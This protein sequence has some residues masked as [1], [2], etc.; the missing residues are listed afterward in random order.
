[1]ITFNNLCLKYVTV[2]FY[3]I[4]RS[5]TTVFNVLFTYYILKEKTSFKA[6]SCCAC[7]IGGFFLGVDQEKVGGSLSPLGVVFGVCASACVALNAIYTK[8]TLPVVSQD[9]WQLQF[10]NNLNAVILF[11]PLMIVCGEIPVLMAFQNLF[12]P[13]FMGMCAVAGICGFAIGSVTGL[14]VKVTSALTHNISGTAKACVQTIIAVVYFQEVKTVLWWFSNAVVLIASAAYT[15][16]RRNEMLAKH[17][18]TVKEMPL[19]SVH[20]EEDDEDEEKRKEEEE[21]EEELVEMEERLNSSSPS[22]ME[23]E[24]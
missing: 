8:R 2:A 11:L 24:V 23:E 10:Y 7:I 19:L 3:N 16:V 6:L 12:S 17:M 13:R 9:I 22:L 1:M 4:G 18:N 5:L 14:Q 20:A 15:Q 21:E